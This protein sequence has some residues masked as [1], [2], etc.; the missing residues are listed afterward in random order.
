MGSQPLAQQPNPNQDRFLSPNPELPTQIPEDSET[1]LSEP[2]VPIEA[3]LETDAQTRILV[4]RIEVIGN[5]VLDPEALLLITQPLEGQE[6]TV[7]E[8]AQAAD[9][10]TQL[11]LE[12]GYVTSRA[13]LPEQEITDGIIQIQIIEGRLGEIQ[14]EGLERLRSGYVR[15]R[16]QRGVTT[17]LN[18]NRL[19]EQLRLLRA[20]PLL[21]NIR[22]RLQP[23]E[24]PGEP[25]LR[26][27]TQEVDP[28]RFGLSVDN[29]S[30]PSIG[31][32]RLGVSLDYQNLSGWGDT[33][34]ASY[35][36]STTGGSS[37][38]DLGYRLPV[39]AMDGTISLRAVFDDNEVTQGAFAGEIDGEVD[40]YE[41]SFRQP[42]IRTLR[43]ELALSTGFTYRDGQTFLG[44]V[45]F[46]FGIGPDK[47]TGISRTSVFGF[48]QD[49]IRRDS[50][51]A[52]ALR[53]QFNIGTDLFDATNNEG[54]VPDS[55]FFSW[56]G[57]VQRVQRLSDDNLLI[58]QGDLQLT[59]DSLLPSEQ[60]V[61]GGG[62]SLRGY[63]QNVR[64]G[65]SGFRFS[66]ED[67]ITLTRD[68]EDDEP[69]IQIAPFIDMGA[70][71][72]NADNP[73]RLGDQNFLAGAG[74]GFLYE[75][76]DGF[77][78]RLD[79]A[80]PIVE[81]DDEGGNAQDQGFYFNVN[82]QY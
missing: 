22:G 18:A 16:L 10:I 44:E 79:Y 80:V 82:Y 66:I 76:I 64:A 70:I 11:Y 77:N 36:R 25:I 9:A 57:Q 35:Y 17:P 52:W 38:W 68:E 63:R 51:G 6:V 67:R 40:R 43:E 81:I 78:I 29:Y 69:V 26:V 1:E 21:E 37:I 28:W 27:E 61:I 41:V 8:L 31:S 75:P 58:I 74:L 4:E 23:S 33:L 60:F 5:T 71:W 65:D 42:L 53:S 15:A 55:Q 73:N 49:Y 72:N 24:I 32:E 39:N 12:A 47:D 59:P 13:V 2:I 45:P 19:E 46:S 62:Q 14:I 20:D 50:Q 54:S 7:E 48:G 30:P 34:S 3:P 56:L